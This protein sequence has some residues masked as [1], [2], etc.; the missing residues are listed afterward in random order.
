MADPAR[1]WEEGR[2]HVSRDETTSYLS[3]SERA[4]LREVGRPKIA[5]QPAGTYVRQILNRLPIDLSWNSSRLEGNTYTLL[6]T[7]RL[8]DLGEEA[9]GKERLEAQMILNHKD[10]VVAVHSPR[11]IG[12]RC[13]HAVREAAPKPRRCRRELDREVIQFGPMARS[14]FPPETANNSDLRLDRKRKSLRI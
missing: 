13:D 12:Q 8:I 1:V 10:A 9:E 6:D 4:H 5:E 7:K 3:Q 2:R 14:T 11:K